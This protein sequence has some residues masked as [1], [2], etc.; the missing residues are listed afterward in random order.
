[1]ALIANVGGTLGLTIGLSFRGTIQDLMD[2]IDNTFFSSKRTKQR[3]KK[4][5]KKLLQRIVFVALT[6]V[7]FL[8][9]SDMIYDYLGG[10][11]SYQVSNQELTLADNPA[12][13][14][15]MDLIH[16]GSVTASSVM[17]DVVVTVSQSKDGVTKN[18]DVQFS[19]LDTSVDEIHSL[20]GSGHMSCLKI[21]PMTYD[22]TQW[23]TAVQVTFGPRPHGY[24]LE[25]EEASLFFTTNDNAHGALMLKFLDGKVDNLILRRGLHHPIKLSHVTE[26]NLV[27]QKCTDLPY[28]HC[29][30][31][32]FAARKE[33]VELCK[34]MTLP[35]PHEIP[36][37][38]TNEKYN[39][40]LNAL[41]DIY[42]SDKCRGMCTVQ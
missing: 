1:M 13:V 29:L 16:Y 25:T 17:D 11:T 36:T 18:V 28:Y 3:V 41:K 5:I 7:T 30:G 6:V 4:G 42:F 14:I 2:Y 19:R 24:S 40:S 33:C 27:Q 23:V 22:L 9:I 38:S 8:F 12:V 37:C 39:C 20:F 32:E 15:C 21:D 34:V 31:S 35:F 10:K 26:Y